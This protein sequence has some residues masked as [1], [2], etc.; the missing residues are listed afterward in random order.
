[1]PRQLFL[2]NALNVA[3][4]MTDG[5]QEFRLY[6][7][8]RSCQLISTNPECIA[9]EIRAVQ[10]HGPV[11]ERRV[12]SLA[13]ICDYACC[14]A[15]SLVVALIPCREQLLLYRFRQPKDSHR[16]STI[17]FKGYSTIPWA[18]AAL[19][20]GRICR[21]T[22]SSMMVFTATQSASLNVEIVGFF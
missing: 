8:C 19:S 1:R 4:C 6:G 2:G 20:F 3:C 14:D 15:F 13:D 16:Q 7:L 22:D 18:F 21:T 9:R 11:S 5:L 17:L 12:A 10:L